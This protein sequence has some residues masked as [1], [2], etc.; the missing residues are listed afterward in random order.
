MM[1][2]A[3][4]IG[5]AEE[6]SLLDRIISSKT[7]ELLAVYGRRRIGKTY[8]IHTHI[9]TYIRFEFSGIHDVG[10]DIQL[11]NFSK[12][13]ANQLN[14]NVPLP[15]PA[16]WFDAFDLL[17]NLLQKYL[18]GKKTIVF[19]D[20]FPWLNTAKSNFLPAFE[21]FWNS[22]ASRQNNL[23]VIL[24]GSAASWMIKNVVRNRGGL[25]NRL[26][27][28]MALMPFSLHEAESFLK[29]RGVNLN[30]YQT[31]Q[32]YMA[33]GGV[34]HY[35]AQARPG[36]SATQIIEET[37]FMNGGF[38]TTEFTDLYS[39]LFGQAENHVKVIRTLAGKPMGMT[40]GE[41]IKACKLQSGGG[42]TS[43]L[44]ELSS[45]GFI[46]AY[47]PFGKKI[48][49]S[50]Y[51]L[52]DPYSLFY[53]KFIEP[54]RNPQ[55]GIWTK[56]SDTPSWKSWSGLAFETICLQHIEEIKRALGIQGVY[57]EPSSW[58]SK[59]SKSDD[60]AQIDLLLDRRDHCITLFEIKFHAGT[61]TLDKQKADALRR[62]LSLFQQQTQTRKQL[63][64]VLI[65]VH[66]LQENEHSLG[67]IDQ[68]VH[69]DQLFIG[70]D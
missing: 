61:I 32:L 58:R 24:C 36:L 67:L 35:L 15:V 23:A 44:E 28:K 46:T 62:K 17:V 26:T 60:A 57:S 5:R 49:D 51:K 11:Q 70:R 12:A 40:R 27:A 34:P 41:I 25:H 48:K 8:L 63:F 1:E 6:K 30:R 19:L 43:L 56:L 42:T 50:L 47:P 65:T 29:S 16:N 52:T 64:L 13:M 31:V 45:S 69:I 55:K 38:L 68:Q 54:N 18:R 2:N 10:T 22:W 9:K 33:L 3:V 20:E 37:C 39:A 21:Q 66:G 4:V 59:A 7:P 14:N 53:L